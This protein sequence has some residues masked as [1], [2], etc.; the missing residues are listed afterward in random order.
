MACGVFGGGGGWIVERHGRPKKGNPFVLYV[1][2]AVVQGAWL[3][4]LATHGVK[5]RNARLRIVGRAIAG[6]CP[7]C[8]ATTA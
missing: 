4:R 1:S 7:D 6:G 5:Y 3:A 2:I 8:P